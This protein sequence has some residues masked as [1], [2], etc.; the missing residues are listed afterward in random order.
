MDEHIEVDSGDVLLAVGTM[1]G[2]LAVR[3]RPGAGEVAG[4]WAALPG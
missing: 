3:G 2:G 1:K 4:E